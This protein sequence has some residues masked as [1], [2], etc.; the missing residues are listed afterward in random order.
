MKV[1]SSTESTEELPSIR[2]LASQRN[3][4]YATAWKALQVLKAQGVAV[5]RPGMKA[6]RAGEDVKSA[7]SR[8]AAVIKARIQEGVYRSGKPLPKIAYLTATEKVSSDTA[9]KSFRQLSREGLV[10]RQGRS[11]FVGSESRRAPGSGK[12]SA[13]AST[14]VVLLQTFYLD[15]WQQAFESH[16]HS[17]F[18]VPLRNELAEHGIGMM[19]VVDPNLVSSTIG[20]PMQYRDVNQAIGDLGDRYRG[21]VT[22]AQNPTDRY[23]GTFLARI[24]RAE[25]PVIYFD[26]RDDS[27]GIGRGKFGIDRWYYRLGFD[28]SACAELAIRSL[29]ELGHRC[30]SVPGA[31]FVDWTRRRAALLVDHAARLAPGMR[32]LVENKSSPLFAAAFGENKLTDF[33]RKLDSIRH[34]TK[35]GRSEP[36][37]SLGRLTALIP[38]VVSHLNDGASA[39]VALNDRLAA[40]LYLYIRALGLSIPRD[41]SIISFD[42]EPLST[43]LPISTID[44]GFARLGYLAA[45]LYVGDIPLRA[46]RTGE[47]GGVPNLVNRGSLGPPPGKP[48]RVLG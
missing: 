22:I 8:F 47:L 13:G 14:P 19:P 29:A 16:Q 41:V 11:W 20:I 24:C 35:A 27:P 38:S 48:R 9:G 26:H 33:V 37:P 21:T 5:T 31:G 39:I 17:S 23:F 25:K 30:V 12:I 36:G 34:E 7:S 42:N 44:F 43:L 3:I 6:A 45:H 46:G 40:H 10:H 32:I 15:D 2:D 28:H 18:M 1:L 4:S